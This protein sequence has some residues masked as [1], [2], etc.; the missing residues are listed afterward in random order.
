[1]VLLTG[2]FWSFGGLIVRHIEAANE[3][4]FLFYRSA[5]MGAI[6]LALVAAL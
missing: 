1:M 2:V 4:Q 5:T 6:F 3:W